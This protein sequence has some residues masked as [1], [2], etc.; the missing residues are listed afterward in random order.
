MKLTAG[1][2]FVFSRDILFANFSIE[3]FLSGL[4]EP[5]SDLRKDIVKEIFDGFNPERNNAGV[6]VGTIRM[7]RL[8]AGY[9][10]RPMG[11][12]GENDKIE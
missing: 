2:S 11:N 3:A 10:L 1:S 5:L 8:W 4:R 6:K 7:D 9:F 12:T